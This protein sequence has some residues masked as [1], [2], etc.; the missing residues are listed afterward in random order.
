MEAFLTLCTVNFGAFLILP[1]TFL[2]N[3]NPVY[4]SACLLQIIF[5]FFLNDTEMFPGIQCE[6]AFA[7][8]SAEKIR[9]FAGA[10]T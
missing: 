1:L 5:S 10:L 7:V 9:N 2:L 8:A 4:T 6:Q 3:L